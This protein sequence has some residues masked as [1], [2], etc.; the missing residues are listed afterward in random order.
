MAK[1]KIWHIPNLRKDEDDG[2]HRAVSWLELFFDLFFVVVI[3]SIAHNFAGDISK[4]GLITFVA[5]FFPIWWIWIGAT[6]Y[7]ERFETEG[8]DNR[9]FTF[10]LMIPVAG[11]AVFAHHA[12]ESNFNYFV[13][14]YIVGRI[15]IAFLWGRAT[16]HDKEFREAGLLFTAGFLIA[17]GFGLAAIQTD[18]N[19]KYTLFGIALF[20]DF[21]AP[22]LTINKS[23]SLPKFSRSKLP[24]R[25][26]LFAIIVLGEVL[27]GV[28]SG[29]SALDHPST[30]I[31]FAG[32]LGIFIVFGL[33][34]VYFDFIARRPFH[35]NMSLQ[36]AWGY[37]H[38]PM[39]MCF[40]AFG[41]A[42]QNIVGNEGHFSEGARLL[43]TTSFG[44]GLIVIAIIESIL[45]RND[46]EMTHRVIS[47][48]LKII[49][50]LISL[51]I[52]IF[53]VHIHTIPL[54]IVFSGLLLVLMFYG[55]YMWFTQEV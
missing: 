41:A 28:I 13:G 5:C 39:V 4:H 9:V 12:L 14:S 31:L 6:Y 38:M 55:A 52:G 54:L 16:Y 19:L 30:N 3:A 47:P 15:I 11:M 25:F 36:Y 48:L 35:E 53:A 45:E 8:L 10:L 18:S 27:V 33:W 2:N 17:I 26:G 44:C 24:E 29:I 40:I 37:L 46:D 34:W 50:G 43:V 51:G 1:R 21:A 42:M 22:M 23:K 49:C 20:L 7:F 32:I